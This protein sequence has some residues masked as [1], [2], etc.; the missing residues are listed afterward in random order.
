MVTFYVNHLYLQFFLLTFELNIILGIVCNVY[1]CKWNP[2][3]GCHT[4]IVYFC[5]T[6]V[7]N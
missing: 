5:M 4:I 3:V 1:I 2:A 7:L 6:Y